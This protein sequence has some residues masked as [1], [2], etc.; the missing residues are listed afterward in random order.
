MKK[1]ITKILFLLLLK[2]YEN[3]Q[4]INR[5]IEIHYVYS[6]NQRRSLPTLFL[7]FGLQQNEFAF[8]LDF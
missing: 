8:I 7:N 6:Y 2:Y 1:L 3:S 4:L 5:E